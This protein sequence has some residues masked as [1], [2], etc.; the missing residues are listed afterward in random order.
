[1]NIIYIHTTHLQLI[2]L[3]FFLF[4]VIS[5]SKLAI[6]NA[7]CLC[8]SEPY[9]KFHVKV[10]YLP[11]MM[12]ILAKTIYLPIYSYVEMDFSNWFIYIL[13]NLSKFHSVPVFLC[14]S[15]KTIGWQLFFFFIFMKLVIEIKNS[16]S[17]LA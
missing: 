8:H 17:H 11:F 2:V 3:E 10:N 7:Q 6:S 9:P 12:Q 16:C 13:Y 5:V 1:M 4:S 15:K 14:F